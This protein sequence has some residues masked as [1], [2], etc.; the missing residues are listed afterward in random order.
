[1]L[2]W[3]RAQRDRA[4]RNREKARALIDAHGD[5]ALD[6]VQARIAETTWQIRDHAHWLR[7]ERH[8]RRMLGR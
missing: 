8:V 7:V 5:A 3:N 6:V 4:R 1:M 2:L